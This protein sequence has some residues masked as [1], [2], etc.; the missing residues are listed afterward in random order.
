[1]SLPN[2]SMGNICG[3]DQTN[4]FTILYYPD[5]NDPVNYKYYIKKIYIVKKSM[6]E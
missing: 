6:C 4:D 2:D 1:M 3:Y 5:I